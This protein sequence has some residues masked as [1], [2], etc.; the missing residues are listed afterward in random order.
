MAAQT[1][2]TLSL[3]SLFVLQSERLASKSINDKYSLWMSQKMRAGSH[4][5]NNQYYRLIMSLTWQRMLRMYFPQ[6]A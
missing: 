5:Q 1:L 2:E 6:V 3:E 4:D